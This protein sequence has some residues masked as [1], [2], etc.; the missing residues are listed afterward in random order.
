M[1]TVVGVVC[2][3]WNGKTSIW[4]AESLFGQCI[5][6]Y[7]N[8][9]SAAFGI[10]SIVLWVF[11]LLPQ[12]HENWR[13]RSTVG[14]STFLLMFWLFGDIMNLTGVVM[15]RQQLF[16]VLLGIYFVMTDFMLVVQYFVYRPAKTVY[17]PTTECLLVPH[18]VQRING[19]TDCSYDSIS[20][21]QIWEAERTFVLSASTKKHFWTSRP[22]KTV[23][24][25]FA[26]LVGYWILVSRW[27]SQLSLS[28]EV[29]GFYMSWGGSISYHVSR[30]PQLWLNW[31]RRSVE[32][33]SLTMFLVILGANGTYAASM[34]SLLPV[35]DAGY[36][37]RS[38]A[39]IYGPIV[40]IILDLFVLAQFNVYRKREVQEDAQA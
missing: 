19:I 18:S 29:F 6:S 14:L 31:K 3:E 5:Y 20:Q 22:V 11:A 35:A 1:S 38:F 34:V 7:W 17:S 23:I 30:L 24:V 4:W 36:L 15:L 40:S 28:Y 10:M 2:P 27:R 21:N 8:A 37:R 12:V 33:L 26:L 25:V 39:F 9:F 32:G 16:Q 13:R